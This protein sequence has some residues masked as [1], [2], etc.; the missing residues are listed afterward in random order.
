[1]ARQKRERPEPSSPKALHFISKTAALVMCTLAILR[2]AKKKRGEAF[3]R[4]TYREIEQLTGFK[5]PQT[6][7]KA[8]D[9]LSNKHTDSVDWIT[10]KSFFDAAKG[11][12]VLLIQIVHKGF[13]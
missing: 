3:F 13:C 9:A 5:H 2:A 4:V 12:R 11:K 1:M 10:R 7:R 6:I 8:L